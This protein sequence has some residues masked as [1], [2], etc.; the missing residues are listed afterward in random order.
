MTLIIFLASFNESQG[1]C[2]R[3]HE[4]VSSV[5]FLDNSLG[6]LVTAVLEEYVCIFCLFLFFFLNVAI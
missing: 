5:V 4:F 6:L 2:L 1:N 3:C